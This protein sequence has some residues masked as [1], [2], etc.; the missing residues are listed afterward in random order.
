MYNSTTSD[1]VRIFLNKKTVFIY[2]CKYT[3]LF[4]KNQIPK[5]EIL[6]KVDVLSFIFSFFLWN[7]ERYYSSI[8]IKKNDII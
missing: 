1:L 8:L 6:D 4:F 2:I 7:K 5:K 3:F